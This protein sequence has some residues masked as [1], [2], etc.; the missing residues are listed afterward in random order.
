M[1]RGMSQ[2]HLDDGQWPEGDGGPTGAS[3]HARAGGWPTIGDELKQAREESGYT[4]PDVAQALR[5]QAAHLQALE[6]CAHD[7]LPGATYA[8][9]FLRSYADYLG[10]D[11]D[12]AVARFKEEAEIRAR[13]TPLV[14][15][16]P[17]G[18]AQRPSSR[19]VLLSVLAAAIAY[20]GW[21]IYDNVDRGLVEDVP[22]PPERLSAL[23]DGERAANGAASTASTGAGQTDTAATDTETG[24]ETAPD[25]EP[26]TAPGESAPANAANTTDAAGVSVAS[27]APN[28]ETAAPA[29]ATAP[30]TGIG[31]TPVDSDPAKPAASTADTTADQAPANAAASDSGADATP[32]AA[33]ASEAKPAA[34]TAD[35]TP[36]SPQASPAVP[37]TPTPTAPTRAAPVAEAVPVEPQRTAAFA[38]IEPTRVEVAPREDVAATPVAEAVV[39]GDGEQVAAADATGVGGTAETA[40]AETSQ[41]PA[42]PAAIAESAAAPVP[43]KNDESPARDD[44][45]AAASVAETLGPATETQIASTPLASPPPAPAISAPSAASDQAGA[46][47]SYR[48]QVYGAANGDAR[49]VIRARADCWVQVQGAD[50]ELLLTR[51][52]R[53]G[54]TYRAPNRGDL[55]LMAGNA[56][57]I[58][59]LLDGELLG[60]LGPDGE[61]RRN[62]PLDAE[63]IRLQVR[64][65][66]RGQP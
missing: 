59:L 37:A 66:N 64:K 30:A 25:K 35:N 47:P 36:T 12:N 40:D 10:L 45:S 51:I 65:G 52:L 29:P 49:V 21:L 3:D 24:E 14:F 56:G 32:A 27:D 22:P 61:V 8:I 15:P 31:A 9:G 5:I 54:D 33:T 44:A 48:P 57:A 4:I 2:K 42:E 39:A 55:L 50:N 46:V 43:A 62:V 13:P 53:A 63:T 7:A 16:Q 19:L 6:D 34:S 1:Q 41:T 58:E 26:V 28:A 60:A 20:G 11:A 18:D 38:H 23:I 17:I